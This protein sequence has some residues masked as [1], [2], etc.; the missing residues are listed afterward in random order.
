MG[1]F[2]NSPYRCCPTV[3]A[4][5]LLGQVNDWTEIQ[6]FK[7]GVNLAGIVAPP[8]S[9]EGQIYHYNK[10]FYLDSA[11][12]RVISRSSNVIITPVTVANTTVE[13]QLWEGTVLS[14]TLVPGKVYK[15]WALGKFSTANASAELTIRT[16]L[17]DVEMASIISSLGKVTDVAGFARAFITI[18]TIGESGTVTCFSSFQLDQESF[19]A[20][21]SSIVLD[22]TVGNN[23][24][25]TA[26]WN[27]ANA[28][29][30]VTIDQGFLEAL[31]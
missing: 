8:S 23:V 19:I 5:D 15:A 12:R 27:A 29:N 30:S 3:I 10:R 24:E 18:R 31:N 4:S 6:T 2:S 20:D 17:N 11:N 9:V 7:K 22:S 26:Q 28:G 21:N 14:N 16:K 1:T 13:T 25:I